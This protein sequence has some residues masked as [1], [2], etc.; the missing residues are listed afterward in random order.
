MSTIIYPP[1]IPWNWMFQRPQHILFLLS[2]L[3]YKV[4]Y[5]DV[6]KF[7]PPTAQDL[8]PDFT[9]CQGVPALSIPHPRPRILWLTVPNHISIVSKYKP[10]LIV[11]DA[12]DVPKNELASW[13]HYYPETIKRSHLI[14]ASAHSI[15][16]RLSKEHSNVHFIPNGVEY[17]H[18]S[19]HM[20][21]PKDLP[22]SPNL[23]GYVGAIAPWV[24][25]ELL[26]YVVKEHPD[27]TFIFIG[28]LLK[29]SR[30]PLTQKNVLYLGYKQYSQLPAYLQNIK[31]GL[32]PFRLTEMTK[33]CN[34]IKLYEY[35]AT[36]LPVLATHLPELH[37]VP[38]IN[39][40]RSPQE[41]SSI[42]K[43]LLK[44][45]D[46]EQKKRKEFAKRNNWHIRAC[47]IDK[48]IRSLVPP[49]V[50]RDNNL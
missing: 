2:T 42:L 25:W 30:F 1:S 36:G 5:E 12:V 32:I 29:M 28:T 16:K 26:D 27:I 31:V 44:E 24:D 14:F 11:F 7:H 50:C 4:L 45:T 41:F 8:S 3:G 46:L 49:E 48:Q 33:G 43:K 10:D 6:G 38:L 18:F 23:I 17:K 13:A 35:Y 20:E 19:K 21:R 22:N 15:Y 39:L 9:L 47:E 40:A 37:S 34:P